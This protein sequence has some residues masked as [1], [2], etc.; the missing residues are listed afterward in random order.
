MHNRYPCDL[1]VAVRYV[2]LDEARNAVSTVLNAV[3]KEQIPYT[4]LNQEV[5]MDIACVL[6]NGEVVF[7]EPENISDLA[8]GCLSLIPAAEFARMTGETADLKEGEILAYGETKG[9]NFRIMG[10]DFRVKHWL[11][12]WPLDSSYSIYGEIRAIVVTDA[13]FYKIDEMQRA[14]YGDTYASGVTAKIGI[15]VEGDRAAK[16]AYREMLDA[17]LTKLKESGAVSENAWIANE[18]RDENY[19]GFYSLYGGLFFL[20]IL[21]GGIFLMGTAMIIYYKQMSEGYEDKERFEIMRKVGMSRKEV[22][23][24]IRRQILMVFFLPLLMA[25]LH[26]TMAFPLIKRLLMLLGMMNTRLFIFC[27]AGTILVFAVVYGI[28][29]GIT[30]RSYYRIL[31]KAK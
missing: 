7:R 6:E 28:I 11:K 3:E 4:K 2:S 15:D 26:I 12:E 16:I 19:S 14:A 20:G 17:N 18:S 30:A 24:S 10:N 29:Y 27:T 25:V 13:D 23:S 8:V 22:K 9:E 5:C 1:N 21:L 31:E